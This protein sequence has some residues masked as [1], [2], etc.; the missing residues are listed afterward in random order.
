MRTDRPRIRRRL[1]A[2]GA[3]FLVPA[4][5]TA[6]HVHGV[7]D[8]G[9]VVE[10]DKVAI[11][12]S[13]PLSDVVGFEHAPEGDEQRKAI[14][15]IAAMLSDADAMFGLTESAGCRISEADVDGP[16]LTATN[17]AISAGGGILFDNLDG[18]W[19]YTPE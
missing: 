16:A 10:G 13:A 5:V 2:F 1:F 11:S 12:M 4:V 19:D 8:L 7:I 3:P 18:T 17:L 15:H 9:V 14:E 6:Q